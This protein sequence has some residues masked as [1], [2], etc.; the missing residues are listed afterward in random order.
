MR[1]D[2]KLLNRSLALAIAAAMTVTSV[3]SSVLAADLFGDGS[4]DVAPVA[5]Q[6]MAE[7]DV[8]D[9]GVEE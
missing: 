2:S 1:K 6:E 4:A 5:V 8:F 9:S 7:T 3:P